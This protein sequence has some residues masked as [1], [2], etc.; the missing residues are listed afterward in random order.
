MVPVTWSIE[1]VDTP[2]YEGAQSAEFT[3]DG[4]QDD[5]TIWL[6][7]A[8]DVTPGAAYT[9]H[10]STRWWS[11]HASFTSA[12]LVVDY[13]GATSPEAE[14]DFT[15]VGVLDQVSGWKRYVADLPA[16]GGADGKLWVGVGFSVVFETWITHDLDDVRIWIE[17]AP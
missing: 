5:G 3:I 1:P 10:V 2:V 12:A 6:E 7:R 17:P 8:F 14:L 15:V 11:E 9:V 16:H 13:A 4:R